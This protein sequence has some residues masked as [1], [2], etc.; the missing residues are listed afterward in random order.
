MEGEQ[1]LVEVLVSRL[2]GIDC[3]NHQARNHKGETIYYYRLWVVSRS[4]GDIEDSLFDV[5]ETIVSSLEFKN[6]A[7]T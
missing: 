3:C 6:G 5:I 1:D 7:F 2:E 4:A